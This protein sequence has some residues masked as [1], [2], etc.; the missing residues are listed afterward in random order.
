M[1]TSAYRAATQQVV[2]MFMLF[3]LSYSPLSAQISGVVFRD[4]NAN[5]I[6]NTNPP[7]II[8]PGVQGV[9]INVYNGSNQIIASYKSGATGQYTIP[10]GSSSYNG[11]QGSNTGSVAQNLPVRIEFVIP[12]SV[13]DNCGLEKGQDFSGFSGSVYGSSVQFA[14]GGAN[15]IHFAIQSPGEFRNSGTPTVFIPCYV[16]GDPLGGGSSGDAEWFV[17]F[18]YTNANLDMPS[19]KLNGK[20]LG[21]VHGVAFSRQAQKVFTSA[22][23]KRHSGLGVLGTGGIYTINYAGNGQMGA[24]SA[25]YN[26]DANGYP[27][28][29]NGSKGALAYGNGSSFSASNGPMN[30]ET[31][32]YLGPTDDL[33]GMPAGLGVVGTN[34]ARGLSPDKSIESHDPA[35][36]DQVGKVGLGDL[37]ISDDGRFLYVTNLYTRKVMRLEL[38]NPYN[39]TAVVSVTEYNIPTFSCNNGLLRPFGLKFYKGK[40]YIGTVCTGEDGGV[41]VVNGNTDLYAQV[42]ELNHA[43]ATNPAW[44]SGPLINIPLNYRK[45]SSYTLGGCGGSSRWKPWTNTFQTTCN[46][47][48]FR[49]VWEQPILSDIEF[50]DDGSMILG[51]MDR[52]GHMAGGGNVDLI[53]DPVEDFLYYTSTGGDMLKVFVNPED[54]CSLR[55]ETAADRTASQNNNQ[56]PNGGEF[57]NTEFF[58][59]HHE[60]AQGTLLRL[61]GT[62]EIMSTVM[63]PF[64][65]NS[66]GLKWLSTSTGATNRNLQLYAGVGAVGF[67]G[68]ANGLGAMDFDMESPPLE[69]GNRIWFDENRNGIQD[70][71][72]Q[73]I[74]GVIVELYRANIKVGETTTSN[75]GHYYFTNNN[76][77]LNG[78]IGILPLTSYE[79]RVQIAQSPL[80][81]FELTIQ[82]VDSGL[83]SD[84]RDSDASLVNDRAVITYTSGNAGEN[85]HTLDIGFFLMDECPEFPTSPGNVIIV[86]SNCNDCMLIEGSITPP[87]IGCPEGSIL[88][89]SL[90]NGNTWSSFLPSYDPS[91]SITIIT[92]CQ[93]VIDEDLVSPSSSMVSTDPGNCPISC[94]CPDLI[95]PPSNVIITDASCDN[96]VPLPGL[97]ATSSN[98]CPSG[99]TIQYST[100]NGNSWSFQLPIYNND[101]SITIITRCL[102]NA[103]VTVFSP[104]S[105]ALSTMPQICPVNCDCPDLL[106]TP[107]QVLIVDQSCI[108]CVLQPGSIVISPSICPTGS[109]PQFSYDNGTT[110]TPIAPVY[111]AND[112][113]TFIIKCDCDLD[114]MVSSPVSIAYTTNPDTCPMSCMCPDFEQA[115]PVV[116]SN[117]LCINCLLEGGTISVPVVPCPSGSIVQYSVNGGTWSTQLPIYNLDVS[118]SVRSRCV[119]EADPSMVSPVSIPVV[120]NPGSCPSQCECPDVSTPPPG[121]IVVDRTCINC[122]QLEGSFSAPS[123]AC[124]PGSQIQYSLDN[125]IVW[126]TAIPVYDQNSSMTIITRCQCLEFPEIVSPASTPVITQPTNCPASCETPSCLIEVLSTSVSI[127]DPFTSTYTLSVT[128]NYISNQNDILVING[129]HFIVEAGINIQRTFELS[130]LPAN[131]LATNLEIGFAD[132]SECGVL[133]ITSYQ[134]PEACEPSCPEDYT[135]D[136]SDIIVNALSLYSI[137]VCEDELLVVVQ[138]SINV[139]CDG[140]FNPQLLQ[141]N[142]GGLPFQILS[143]GVDFI[144]YSILLESGNFSWSFTYTNPNGEEISI[145]NDVSVE[146]EPNLPAIITMPSVITYT[147]SYCAESPLPFEIKIEDD[148][149]DPINPL[150]A[151]FEICG[152]PIF[153]SSFDPNTGIFT[154]LLEVKPELHNCSF[155]V[156]YTDNHG[157]ISNQSLL[158]LVNGSSD[159]FPPIIVY[160]SEDITISIGDC[161]DE[162]HYCFY[163]SAYD[164]C[165]GDI[166]PTVLMNGVEIFPAPGTNRYCLTFFNDGTFS[167]FITASDS[168]GNE[169]EENFNIIVNQG[170]TTTVNLAC[171]E[172]LNVSLGNNCATVITAEMLLSGSFGCLSDSNFTITITDHGIT[173]PNPIDRCGL[174]MYEVRLN[175]GIEANFEVCWGN[176]LVED[177]L[178]PTIICSEASIPCIQLESLLN[179]QGA[180][181]LTLASTFNLPLPIIRDNCGIL[182]TTFTIG[183]IMV[184]NG[185]GTDVCSERFVPITISVRDLCG[186]ISSCIMMVQIMPDDLSTVCASIRNY[187]DID[188]DAI[189]CLDSRLSNPNFLDSN[190]NPLPSWTGRPGLNLCNIHCSYSDINIPLCGINISGN[191]AGNVP[192]KIARTWTCLDWCAP[193]GSNIQECVQVIKIKDMIGPGLIVQEPAL[194]SM[195]NSECSYAM[196]FTAPLVTESC[197]GIS[198]L[199]LSINGAQFVPFVNGFYPS[200]S[201]NPPSSRR[202]N[203]PV[204]TLNIVYR[205]VDGCGNVTTA[206]VTTELE[207]KTPPIAICETFRVSSLGSDC[208]VRIYAD[209]FN[210]GSYDN[211]TDISLD[212][213]RVSILNA[214]GTPSLTAM[215]GTECYDGSTRISRWNSYNTFRDWVEFCCN[216]LTADASTRMVELRIRDAFGNSSSCMVTVDVQDKLPPS[217]VRPA[218][219]TIDCN[220]PSMHWDWNNLTQEQRLSANAVFGTVVLEHPHEV[221]SIRRPI[222]SAVNNPR[223]DEVQSGIAF[224]DG[225]AWDNCGGTLCFSMSQSE[226]FNPIDCK[227]G[228]IVRSWTIV[229]GGGN[230]IT[231]NQFIT[232]LN[233]YPFNGGPNRRTYNSNGYYTTF[234]Q[235]TNS[236]TDPRQWAIFGP[237]SGNAGFQNGQSEEGAFRSLFRQVATGE[238]PTSIA[239]RAINGYPTR[240]DI[241]WPADLMIDICSQGLQPEV[242]AASPEWRSGSKPYLWREDICSQVGMTYDEWNFDFEAGCRKVIR[243]WKVID[244]CQPESVVQPWTWVQTI[245]VVDT[246]GP[247]FNGITATIR[248]GETQ[249]VSCGGEVIFEFLDLCNTPELKPIQLIAQGSD[250]CGLANDINNIR[251]DWEVYPFGDR[252]NVV[253]RSSFPGQNFVPR[254]SEIEVQQSFP[255]T[256]PGGPAHVIKFIAED[257]CSN[258][259][260]CE[261]SFRIE[262]RK[263]PTPIC[264]ANLSTDVMPAGPMAGSVSIEAS[265]FNNGSNDNCTVGS[266]RLGQVI[267]PGQDSYTAGPRHL[268]TPQNTYSALVF[269]CKCPETLPAGIVDCESLRAPNPSNIRLVSPGESVMIAMWVGDNYG[270][271]D[272]CL[273]NLRVDNHMG[274]NCDE[275]SMGMV[276]GSVKSA[277]NQGIEFV[278]LMNNWTDNSGSYMIELPANSDYLIAPSRLDNPRNGVNVADI[279]FIQRHILG[280]SRLDSPYKLIAAD[281]DNSRTINAQDLVEIRKVLLGVIP[282]FS[283]APSWKFIPADYE[284]ANLDIAHTYE[285]PGH[286][287][288]QVAD[289]EMVNSDFLGIKTGDVNYSAQPNSQSFIPIVSRNTPVT[290]YIENKYVKAGEVIDISFEV[291]EEINI[292]GL[293]MTFNF[294]PDFLQFI[295]IESGNLMASKENVGRSFLHKGWLPIVLDRLDEGVAVLNSNKLFGFRF[296]VLADASLSDLISFGSQWIDAIGVVNESDIQPLQLS[297]KNIELEQLSFELFQN[298]P[299]PF[300]AE[301]LISFSLPTDMKAELK[302]FDITGRIVKVIEGEF[303]EGLNNVVIKKQDLPLQGVIYYQLEAEEFKATKKMI[304]ID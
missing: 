16:N 221:A 146:L 206:S 202:I 140:F 285:I 48:N 8:E 277:L 192:R 178:P 226:V 280:Q 66:G 260:V 133:N 131:G 114:P 185:G 173:L 17:A 204:G 34:A 44:T 49:L 72:E 203:V 21:T 65:I 299:N 298:R 104:S 112:P 138:V 259:S 128:I 207:D 23:V 161:E 267:I 238:S 304:L 94:E 159:E 179:F 240:F 2:A 82:N 291:S 9:I 302:F 80:L 103:D 172:Q 143:I 191:F 269:T 157:N 262:D 91:T 125:G 283:I 227:S 97:I 180:N 252:A 235:A 301:T 186:N 148:C 13:A 193:N 135:I 59:N 54:N 213:R 73:G 121:I 217:G 184:L 239:S 98:A 53:A 242:L 218:D 32:T 70:A 41:N 171:V 18:P 263:K 113:I 164:D 208:K 264:F 222:I 101:Q 276:T 33:T 274:A 258:K 247:E 78:A 5:G 167:I 132:Q 210:D 216:D 278:E 100:N 165:D 153:P 58:S 127:C 119:C 257:G 224:L 68:K 246:D 126:T 134:A 300:G 271:W 200:Q 284:F 195:N 46:L 241:V 12:E 56:G 42:F 45:G 265:L 102:C 248:Q 63:D 187:D 85:D 76:V 150:N 266:I 255:R 275:V 36:F 83:N 60:T 163:V 201:I 168:N 57:F 287:T 118:V 170:T 149:E 74:D 154:F 39:P 158:L 145:A 81:S 162:I 268:R 25:F 51:F 129:Q 89:Y 176:L 209:A 64:A 282:E 237:L 144:E 228:V 290:L 181:F 106:S 214:D 27:T 234:R 14:N 183:N 292:G 86:D 155:E 273:A 296:K 261:I 189:S 294:D 152:E 75:G 194:K 175:S 225:I 272:Y 15:N 223:I 139:P 1:T 199:E 110:W 43:K 90:N 20:V 124:P 61:P 297:F 38:N 211:C 11:L 77:N 205:A 109:A 160:P 196:V 35:A 254:G 251:W 188:F 174:F 92:R 281:V 79:I 197:S 231:L 22:F 212:V 96:C 123:F 116:I 147:I 6:Q 26:L 243:Q 137:P 47:I 19:G 62:G 270:N 232:V 55:I 295:S 117:S 229:D 286:M 99:S 245:K 279:I 220:D 230:T 169:R 250:L 7:N 293:Q 115:S 289:G 253:K 120:T 69:I 107:D 40:L 28:R 29:Y 256:L 67:L 303:Y 141:V 108:N 182:D 151:I 233:F 156:T 177:K 95:I 3:L 24:V 31:V 30:S 219:L 136:E 37:A 84:L 288:V 50:A 105:N 166:I 88:Q 52:M 122:D 190:G 93:C 130:G 4:F 142:F 71:N 236:G 111:S 249:S 198:A 87:S 215:P 244:W 10:S